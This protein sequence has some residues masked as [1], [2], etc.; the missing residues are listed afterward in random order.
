MR[1]THYSSQM[2]PEGRQP[3]PGEDKG[4][5]ENKMDHSTR[6]QAGR[7][8]E[9]SCHRMPTGLDR[10]RASAVM[11]HTQV[12]LAPPCKYAKTHTLQDH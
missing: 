6:L 9:L 2:G 10:G 4:E 1:A 12:T 7:S 3:E 5:K 8:P 11:A